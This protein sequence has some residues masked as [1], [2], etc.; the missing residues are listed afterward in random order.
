MAKNKKTK[1]VKAV[2]PWRCHVTGGGEEAF[3]EADLLFYFFILDRPAG[4]PYL[5]EIRNHFPFVLYL[6]QNRAK[7][8]QSEAHWAKRSQ[9]HEKNN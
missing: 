7:S 8:H 5:Q 4:S 9:Q 2:P 1:S 3:R 6:G